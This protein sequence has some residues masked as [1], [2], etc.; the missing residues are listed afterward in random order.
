[1]QTKRMSFYESMTNMLAGLVIGFTAQILFFPLFGI[2][3]NYAAFGYFSLLMTIV[4]TARSYGIRRAFNWL[5]VV[6]QNPSEIIGED[7][8]SRWHVVPRNR[9]LN[10][11]LHRFTG[12]DNEIMHDHPWW[13]FSIALSGF[14]LEFDDRS[15]RP[16]TIQ[17][18]TVRVR[19]PEYTHR[20]QIASDEVWTLFIT[21]CRVREWGFHCPDGWKHWKDFTIN[22]RAGGCE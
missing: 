6:M 10:V 7:Y 4:M 19:R 12:S 21:G 2:E 11:Y 8:L 1:M 22:N 9:F 5:H 18:W 16:R 14:A 13:S 20:I 15:T 17:K 3:V